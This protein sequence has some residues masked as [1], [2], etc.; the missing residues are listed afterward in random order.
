MAD[1]FWPLGHSLPILD[2]DTR[3]SKVKVERTMIQETYWKS[4][5]FYFK[6]NFE[7]WNQKDLPIFKKLYLDSNTKKCWNRRSLACIPPWKQW[8]GNHPWTKVPLWVFSDLGKRLHIPGKIQDW[9]E[10][11]W[12]GSPTLQWQDLPN[13]VSAADWKQLHHTKNWVAALLG[14]SPATNPVHQ[15]TLEEPHASVPS[16]T[17]PPTT[18]LTADFEAAL[19]TSSSSDVLWSGVSPACPETWQGT[20]P[21]M[22]SNNRPCD[23]VPVPLYG[24]PKSVLRIQGPTQGLAESPFRELVEATHIW[25]PRNRSITCG[26]NCEPRNG[27]MIELQHC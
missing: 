3:K 21:T 26:L 5:K 13:V 15:W 20:H 27:P 8:S 1:Q 10:P 23:P 6:P 22:P 14:Y 16:V 7:S 11:L 2:L 24:A 12:E 18:D 17:G 9:G 4:G 25:A 19:W